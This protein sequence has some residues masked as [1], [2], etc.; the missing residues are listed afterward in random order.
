MALD[1]VHWHADDAADLGR[2]E[3]FLIAQRD[4]QPLPLRQLGHELAQPSRRQRIARRRRNGHVRR[5]VE[6][7]PTRTGAA[8]FVDAAPRR[9]LPQPKHEVWARLDAMEIAVELEEDV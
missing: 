6:A 2:I 3:I 4:H 1:G 9:Y 8:H 7:H 5:V